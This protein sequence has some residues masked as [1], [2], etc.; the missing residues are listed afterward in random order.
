MWKG[1]LVEDMWHVT[2]E[3]CVIS[4]GGTLFSYFGFTVLVIVHA[5]SLT[6][7]QNGRF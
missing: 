7:E 5:G 4:E 1:L 2:A 6:A 3:K